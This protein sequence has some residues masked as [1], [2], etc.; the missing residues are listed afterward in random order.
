MKPPKLAVGDRVAVYSGVERHTGYVLA[1][2]PNGL[3]RTRG[4]PRPRPFGSG[5]IW[6]ATFHPKQCRRLIKKKRPSRR[7]IWLSSSKVRELDSLG[8]GAAMVAGVRPR[9]HLCDDIE[10]IEI[11]RKPK[12]GAREA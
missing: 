6:E 5:N 2:E 12:G 7:R 1:V 3:I 9:K 8:Y 4:D 10:F 11:R